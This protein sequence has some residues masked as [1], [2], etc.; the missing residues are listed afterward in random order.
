MTLLGTRIQVVGDRRKIPIDY[1][2]WLTTGEILTGVVCT[3]D[4]GSATVDTIVI[5]PD[6]KGASFYINDGTLGDL[7]NVIIEVNTNYT[8]R[9]Y[10]TMA[11]QVATN[12]GVT[13][14]AGNTAL[15]LSIIGP[16]GPTGPT[17]P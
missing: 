12:G 8:Q 3:V 1:G 17:G 7:F 10:D 9:R 16:T 11:F 4:Q 2:D 15:M 13:L 14:V 5:D 6:A